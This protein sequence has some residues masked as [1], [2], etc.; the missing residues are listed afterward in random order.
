MVYDFNFSSF[1]F[2]LEF[3][4]VELIFIFLSL[5]TSKINPVEKIEFIR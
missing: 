5:T 4:D 3:L 1:F 2:H